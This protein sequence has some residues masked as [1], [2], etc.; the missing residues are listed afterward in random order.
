MGGGLLV[1]RRSILPGFGPSIKNFSVCYS[2]QFE[3][4]TVAVNLLHCI[5]VANFCCYRIATI[6]IPNSLQCSQVAKLPCYSSESGFATVATKKCYSSG[7]NCSFVA[8]PDL[9]RC[10]TQN[11]YSSKSIFAAVALKIA[12]V[13]IL[14]ATV[15]SKTATVAS[16]IAGVAS[17]I[18][19]K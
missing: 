3:L 6:A 13:A 17:K 16:G 1:Q 18:A 12:T 4:A 14:L 19:K 15:A 7:R 8:S 11:C 10:S 2:S 5:Q 9:V